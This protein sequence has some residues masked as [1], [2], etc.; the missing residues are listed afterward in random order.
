[1]HIPNESKFKKSSGNNI[2]TLLV[3]AGAILLFVFFI[4]IMLYFAINVAIYI[5][6]VIFAFVIQMI[7]RKRPISRVLLN[8]ALGPFYL[9]FIVIK[10]ISRK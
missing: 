9:G 3:G 7:Q 2:I 1:M 5:G 8:S 6:F 10:K 4:L